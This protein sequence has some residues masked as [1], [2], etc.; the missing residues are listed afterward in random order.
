M[1]KGQDVVLLLKLIA[2]PDA[3]EWPQ[4]KLAEHLCMSVSTV[5]GSFKRLTEVLL[6]VWQMSIEQDKYGSY[7]KDK[8]VLVKRNVHE[9]I[10]H[11]VKYIFAIDGCGM[12][13]KT[14]IPTGYAGLMSIN[15]SDTESIEVWAYAKGSHIGIETK[16]LYSSVPKSI[17]KFKDDK[18]YELLCLIDILRDKDSGHVCHKQVTEY[19]TYAILGMHENTQ[20]V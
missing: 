7:K 16:P 10:I 3:L 19:L 6:I 13:Y 20:T 8:Y 1:I 17:S 5:N 9:F 2:N 12:G 15:F 11:T 18:F 4:K 14:G